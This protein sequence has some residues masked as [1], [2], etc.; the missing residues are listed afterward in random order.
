MSTTCTR[1]VPSLI[2]DQKG[3]GYNHGRWVADG[4]REKG[5]GMREARGRGGTK[6]ASRHTGGSGGGGSTRAQYWH[7]QARRRQWPGGIRGHKPALGEQWER[8]MRGEGG[9]FEGTSVHE[10]G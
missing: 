10:G 8:G 9:D 1:L 6:S 5:R 7:G 4:R 3:G 2:D